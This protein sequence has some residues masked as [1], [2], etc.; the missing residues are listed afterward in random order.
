MEELVAVIEDVQAKP[1]GHLTIKNCDLVFTSERLLVVN[2]GASS[3]VAGMLGQAAAG[4]GGAMASGRASG[5][6]SRARRE[7]DA[8]AGFDEMLARDEGNVAIPYAGVTGGTFKTGFFS[9]FWIMAPLT[10]DHE[11]GRFFCNVPYGS[12]DATKAALAGTLPA[13]SIT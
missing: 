1:T 3:F 11:G 5:E 9:T 8:G 2:R 6:A 12:V 4:A 13:V 7:A 10:I